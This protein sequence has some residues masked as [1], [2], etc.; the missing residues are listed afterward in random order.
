VLKVDEPALP[1]ESQTAEEGVVLLASDT[2]S[3]EQFKNFVGVP[4]KC[5][6]RFVEGNRYIP[7]ND[8]LE[9]RPAPSVDPITGDTEYPVVGAGFQV[10][11]IHSVVKK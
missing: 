11:V 1:P 3:F 8:N 7:P 5:R 4:V 2:V 9:Q 10:R 6:G